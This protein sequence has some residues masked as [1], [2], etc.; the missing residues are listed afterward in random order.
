METIYEDNKYNIQCSDNRIIIT[1]VIQ[2]IKY[3][4]MEFEG[5]HYVKLFK[6]LIDNITDNSAKTLKLIEEN[7]VLIKKNKVLNDE[8]DTYVGNLINYHHE[9]LS[10]DL[11]NSTINIQNDKLKSQVIDLL[12]QIKNNTSDEVQRLS[13]IIINLNILLGQIS[14]KNNSLKAKVFTQRK[15]GLDTDM[16]NT[17][18]KRELDEANS[19]I[20]DKQDYILSF[21]NDYH[22]MINSI[23]IL[24]DKNT[25]KN[26]EIKNILEQSFS[27][28]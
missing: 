6:Y 12:N 7:K 16:E 13:E 1:N 18:L 21:K 25:Y 3:K 9:K 5:Q 20:K 23:E 15:Y 10:I 22:G 14:K 19:I 11:A 8:I 27:I 2:G 17:R 24:I 28:I 26:L 4:I